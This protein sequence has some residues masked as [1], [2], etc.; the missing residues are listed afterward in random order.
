MIDIDKSISFYFCKIYRFLRVR[1]QS[2]QKLMTQIIFCKSDQYEHQ[3]KL[4]LLVSNMLI[5]FLKTVTK[6]VQK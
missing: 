5:G 3:R 4:Y 1:I 6:K 2:L